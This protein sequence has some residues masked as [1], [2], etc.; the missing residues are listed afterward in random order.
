M[1]DWGYR[2]ATLN[3][4]LNGSAAILLFMGWRAIRSQNIRRHR[5]FMLSAFGVS[6]LFLI[7]YLTRVFSFG[8]RP[9]PGNGLDKT[10]YL[11]LLASH[12]VLAALVPFLA[13]GAIYWAWRGNFSKHRKV[14][15]VTFP[16]WMY[17]SITGVTIY[18]MLYHFA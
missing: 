11:T 3:S 9:Y 17:V 6:C 10:F 15:A 12:V 18:L 7:S 5:A 16:I 8:T 2:L 14:A 1:S 13:L 4:I